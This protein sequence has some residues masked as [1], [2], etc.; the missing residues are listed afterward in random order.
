LRNKRTESSW[1]LPTRFSDEGRRWLAATLEFLRGALVTADQKWGQVAGYIMGNEVKLALVVGE[2]GRATMEEF[3]DD[4]LRTVRL[5]HAAIRKQS[6]WAR[7][8]L[9]LE[10]HWNIRY[11]EVTNTSRSGRAFLDTSRARRAAADFDWHLAFHPLPGGIF[12]AALLE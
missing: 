4:Y 7:V 8:Y 1:Q 9:S 5:A 10:H 2:P 11:A 6:S 12:R 3:A